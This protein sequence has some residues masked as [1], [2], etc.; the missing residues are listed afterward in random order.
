MGEIEVRHA[1]TNDFSGLGLVVAVGW[2]R[3]FEQKGREWTSKIL[4]KLRKQNINRMNL[5]GNGM[6]GRYQAWNSLQ[7]VERSEYLA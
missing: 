1:Q 5:L 3:K 7:S 6:C 4:E 2:N